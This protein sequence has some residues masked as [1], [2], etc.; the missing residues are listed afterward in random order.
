MLHLGLGDETIVNKA[1]D[2]E[3]LLP[4]GVTGEPT[5]RPIP[6]IYQVV[7]ETAYGPKFLTSWDTMED[8]MRDC[9]QLNICSGN[10]FKTVLW[11]TGT[12]C[13]RCTPEQME[14][15]RDNKLPSFIR[16][17]AAIQTHP[18]AYP[19]SAVYNHGT[20]VVFLQ[21]GT[22]APAGLGVFTVS[23][24]QTPWTMGQ[25]M[26]FAEAT[27]VA[28]ERAGRTGSATVIRAHKRGKRK[29]IAAAVVRLG[30]KKTLSGLGDIDMNPI[31]TPVTPAEFQRLVE[32][33]QQWT[34]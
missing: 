14:F 11:G 15:K 27:K 34:G 20:E 33:S 17:S 12:P 24:A 5:D 4:V 10:P 32:M 22:A 19:V 28:K 25:L 1:A 21:D 9:Q 7:Q 18:E 26:N 8:A 6:S 16:H 31:I 23:D 13:L 2:K 30:R 3:R 29:G